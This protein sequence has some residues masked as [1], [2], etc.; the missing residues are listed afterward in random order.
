MPPLLA[1]CPGLSDLLLTVSFVSGCAERFSEE[2]GKRLA[3][4]WAWETG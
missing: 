1:S 4:H 2:E 3:H